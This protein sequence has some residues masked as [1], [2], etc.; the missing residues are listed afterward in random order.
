MRFNRQQ[1]EAIQTIDRILP[2]AGAGREHRG[3]RN[4]LSLVK[5]GFPKIALSSLP[6][7]LTEKSAD[8]MKKRI[9]DRLQTEQTHLPL[10]GQHDFRISTIHGFCA[11]ILRD[12][13]A[14]AG[15]DP[16]FTVLEEAEAQK[17]LTGAMT[18]AYARLVIDADEGM[19]IR[20]AWHAH[21]AFLSD[22]V[23]LYHRL[24]A[25]AAD[26]ER[27]IKTARRI[28]LCKGEGFVPER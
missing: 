6:L 11:R 21:N 19:L 23:Q 17:M 3:G 9:Q 8:E 1:Q 24:R 18:E 20:H 25:G 5:K 16:L 4:G 14:G 22:A 27:Y 13:P 12:D 15:V 28:R 10:R 7:L 26:R 2:V